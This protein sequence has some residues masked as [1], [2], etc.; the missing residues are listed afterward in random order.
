MR[1]DQNMSAASPLEGLPLL[2]DHRELQG[3]LFSLGVPRLW[4][5]PYPQWDRCMTGQLGEAPRRPHR[6]RTLSRS[7][8]R[9]RPRCPGLR[10]VHIL[11][12]TCCLPSPKK[13]PPFRGGTYGSRGS[14]LQCLRLRDTQQVLAGVLAVRV[15]PLERRLVSSF[16]RF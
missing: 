6:C 4:G 7:L 10:Y 5:H 13:R 9:S 14:A 1:L 3:C 15:S 16:A 12:N 11:A 8:S 2:L